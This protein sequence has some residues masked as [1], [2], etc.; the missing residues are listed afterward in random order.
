MT[1]GT[2][3]Q[4]GNL[5]FM[6]L[7]PLED[8]QKNRIVVTIVDLVPY[9]DEQGVMSIIQSP[10]TQYYHVP[11]AGLLTQETLSR[12][13]YVDRVEDAGVIHAVAYSPP[14]SAQVI[15]ILDSE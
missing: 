12:L 14:V 3:L 4:G 2:I 10:T 7:Y 6:V 13:A 9:V 15:A 1:P 11:G 8:D 5:L